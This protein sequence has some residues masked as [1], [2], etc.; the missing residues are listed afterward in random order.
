MREREEKREVPFSWV[1]V[2]F[3]KTEIR[4][5]YKNPGDERWVSHDPESILSLL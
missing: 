4:S 5:M 3:T 1:I 2:S